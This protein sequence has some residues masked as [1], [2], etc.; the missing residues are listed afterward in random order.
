MSKAEEVAMELCLSPIDRRFI[1][2]N[3]PTREKLQVVSDKWHFLVVFVG[4]NQDLAT[5]YS[6]WARFLPLELRCHIMIYLSDR[7]EVIQ[8]DFKYWFLKGKG[9]QGLTC[10]MGDAPTVNIASYKSVYGEEADE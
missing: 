10:A 3:E 9:R 2:D 1:F 6:E 5:K 4:T 7:P 8:L